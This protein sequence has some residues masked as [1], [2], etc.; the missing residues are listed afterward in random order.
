MGAQSSPDRVD[1]SRVD[2]SRAR[3]VS[4]PAEDGLMDEAA[5]YK[6]L[7]KENEGLLRIQD[8]HNKHHPKSEKSG[9]GRDAEA[10]P[11]SPTTCN[12]RGEGGRGGTNR[13]MVGT[14][15]WVRR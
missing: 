15:G 9:A 6:H 1:A 8:R 12:V 11:G 5:A 4:G 2:D 13:D 10:N 14:H 3:D 7:N